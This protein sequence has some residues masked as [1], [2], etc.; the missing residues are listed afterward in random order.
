MVEMKLGS[1]SNE[2]KHSKIE[3]LEDQV[4]LDLAEYLDN[5]PN[6][7]FAIRILA[8]ESGLNPKTIRRLLAREN[9][10]TYQTLHKLYSIFLEEDNYSQL[11]ARCP[12]VVADKIRDYNP[13]DDSQKESR[14]LE[15]LEMLKREPLLAELY[16]LAGTSPLNKNAVAFRYGQYGVEVLEK[17]LKEDLIQEIEKD[18]YTLTKTG[19]T[20]DGHCLKYLG[21]YFVRRF[22]KADN[23]QVH[24][25]N[26]LN[27]YAEGLNEQGKVEWLRVD[28]EAFYKKIEIANDPKFKGTIPV[29]TF[30]ATDT[31]TPEKKND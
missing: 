4:A 12:K 31:I 16:I 11:L 25:E 5:F 24:N 7:T 1:D 18:T 30:T 17:L 13:C 14:R 2:Q 21:E 28:T 27:F 20:M 29:F 8:K 19:P 3:T 15:F 10:P 22:A 26:M 9:K 6:K 23:T